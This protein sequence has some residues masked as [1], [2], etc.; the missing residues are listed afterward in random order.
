MAMKCRRRA[1]LRGQRWKREAGRELKKQ[2][3]LGALTEVGSASHTAAVGF[4]VLR[5]I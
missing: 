1:W 3:E 4:A 2:A 5:I